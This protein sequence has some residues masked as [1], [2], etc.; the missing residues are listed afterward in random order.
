MSTPSLSLPPLPTGERILDRLVL[1]CV[2]KIFSRFFLN[3]KKQKEFT[4][5]RE[6]D[7]GHTIGV[8]TK[9]NNLEEKL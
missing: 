4:N 2:R 6:G 5:N 9:K 1:D 8:F 3:K 7:T